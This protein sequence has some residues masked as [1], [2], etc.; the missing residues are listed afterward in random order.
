MP[1]AKKPHVLSTNLAR[2]SNNLRPCDS[3]G[4]SVDEHDPTPTLL[5]KVEEYLREKQSHENESQVLDADDEEEEDLHVARHPVLKKG[6][7]DAR[8]RPAA[9]SA[10]EGSDNE[11]DS[12][13]PAKAKK[14]QFIPIISAVDGQISK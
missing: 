3:F 9:H 12:N 1:T 2:E 14:A 8:K 5:E 7:K 10:A 13:S 4:E 11:T 6:K